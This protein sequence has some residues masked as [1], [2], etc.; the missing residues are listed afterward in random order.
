[1]KV[2]LMY[3]YQ[4]FDKEM[5]LPGNTTTLVE[6]LHLNILFNA[7]AKGDKFL[8]NVSTVTLLSG[9][10]DVETI[11]YRQAILKDCL[12]N[13]EIVRELYQIPIKS[14]ERKQRRWLGIFSNSASGALSNAVSMM[15]MFIVLLKDLKTLSVQHANRFKSA[16]FKRFFAFIQQELSTTFFEE[17]ELHLEQ[18]KFPDGVLLSATLGK[19]NES[20]NLILRKANETK[21]WLKALFSKQSSS[22]SFSIS[23]R[24]DA[25]TRALSDIKNAATYAVAKS[26]SLAASHID[27]FFKMLKDELAFYVA[28]LNLKDSLDRIGCKTCFPVPTNAS[29][30]H[31]SFTDLYDVNLALTIKKAIVGNKLN[32]DEK[33]LAIITGANQGGKTTFLR[34]IGLAQLMMQA[35]MFVPA[36]V[37]SANISQG[38]YTHFRREEDKSLRSGKLDE[39]L[40]RMSEIIDQLDPNALILFNESFAATNEQEGSEIAQQITHALIESQ[41][42]VF[43]VTHMTEFAQSFFEKDLENIVFLR[44]DRD[45][46]GKRNYKITPGMPLD[47]SFGED[48]FKSIFSK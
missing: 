13:S 24:D 38:V 26:L 9:L 42:K 19:G 20:D 37:F 15:E 40:K 5:H 48:I 25:G 18:L 30:R 6:D 34:S 17:A 11:L 12:A 41:M 4:D 14:A 16:G 2:F 31:H 8:W 33:S 10:N 23:S 39:E 3:P 47:T 45:A 44:A 35:G 46:K 22:Y 43:F 32:A 1:M 29:E 7:M 27:A 21:N 28:C 36:D